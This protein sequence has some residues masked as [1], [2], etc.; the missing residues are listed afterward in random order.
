MVVA[1]SWVVFFGVLLAPTFSQAEG[2]DPNVLLTNA[3]REG[4]RLEIIAAALPSP[5]K[6]AM[7]RLE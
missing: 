6:T 4:T 3:A 2:R 1:V 7:E 5:N